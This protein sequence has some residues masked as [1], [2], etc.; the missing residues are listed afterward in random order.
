MVSIVELVQALKEYYRHDYEEFV[1]VTN[2][3]I[4]EIQDDSNG[5]AYRLSNE[6]GSECM[7]NERCPLCGSELVTLKGYYEDRGEY[8]GTPCTEYEEVVGCE[9]SSCPYIIN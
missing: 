5:L 9:D 1:S 2:E 3:L 7:D 6:L 8:Q 4:A